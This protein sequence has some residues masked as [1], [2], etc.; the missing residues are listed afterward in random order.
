[1]LLADEPNA[2]DAEGKSEQMMVRLLMAAASMFISSTFF[3]SPVIATPASH[4]CSPASSRNHAS[5]HTDSQGDATPFF[6]G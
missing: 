6:L 5:P 2:H 1:M 4:P 3:F